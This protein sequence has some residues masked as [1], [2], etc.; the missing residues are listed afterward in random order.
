LGI[1]A[2]L[3]RTRANKAVDALQTALNSRLT[4][5]DAALKLFSIAS[6]A[7]TALE[8][9]QESD[10]WKAF[11]L[12]QGKHQYFTNALLDDLST[13]EERIKVLRLAAS[14]GAASASTNFAAD[15]TEVK[16]MLAATEQNITR[17]QRVCRDMVE[18]ARA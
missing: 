18:I 16:Q 14:L 1:F 4:S 3:F 15:V 17:L 9:P 10:D 5:V 11:K 7:F 8:V 2:R 13:V 6:D 12:A